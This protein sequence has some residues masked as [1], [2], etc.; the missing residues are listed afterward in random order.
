MWS[1]MPLIEAEAAIGNSDMHPI[2][3]LSPWPCSINDF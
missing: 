1:I 2:M 3:V